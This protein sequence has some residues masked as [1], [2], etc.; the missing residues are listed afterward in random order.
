MRH[1]AGKVLNNTQLK[2]VYLYL[3]KNTAQWLKPQ[4][5]VSSYKIVRWLIEN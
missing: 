4:Q 2:Q 1:L 3:F 5:S